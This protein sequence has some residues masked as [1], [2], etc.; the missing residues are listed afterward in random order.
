MKSD[1]HAW[2]RGPRR[3]MIFNPILTSGG[4]TVQLQDHTKINGGKVQTIELGFVD[5]PFSSV[6]RG[7]RPAV[8]GRPP[9]SP[10]VMLVRFH[11]LVPFPV[12]LG[13]P[14]N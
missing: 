14:F 8:R 7:G 9:P 13:S 1:T 11:K 2:V 12:P 10:Q 5:A 6:G 4:G 3:A